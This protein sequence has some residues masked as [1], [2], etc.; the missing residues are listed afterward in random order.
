MNPKRFSL[1]AIGVVL[2]TAALAIMFGFSGHG[3]AGRDQ[4]QDGL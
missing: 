3:A 4:G 1:S 2:C